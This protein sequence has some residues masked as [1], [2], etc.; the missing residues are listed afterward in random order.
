MAEG[1]PQ[2][3]QATDF[4]TVCE[5][6]EWMLQTKA[7]RFYLFRCMVCGSL[8]KTKFR[9][10]TKCAEFFAGRCQLGSKCPN[11][12]IYSKH[13][14]RK[15]TQASLGVFRDSFEPQVDPDAEK[16]APRE[17][18]ADMSPEELNEIIFAAIG[19]AKE[20]PD[21]APTCSLQRGDAPPTAPPPPRPRADDCFSSSCYSLDEGMHS[22][23]ARTAPC[24]QQIQ[25][26][27]VPNTYSA[28]QPILVANTLPLPSVRSQALAP[29]QAAPTLVPAPAQMMMPMQ[30]VQGAMHGGYVLPPV[31]YLQATYTM[32]QVMHPPQ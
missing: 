3:L 13:R 21:T 4:P 6:N 32:Q 12:H 31:H 1:H 30:P 7:K 15:D 8:W 20:A 27:V 14:A 23:F 2:I 29:L 28:M 5:H 16:Q 11:P 26:A 10:T 25:T 24:P 9:T 17:G 22:T 19:D 18:G